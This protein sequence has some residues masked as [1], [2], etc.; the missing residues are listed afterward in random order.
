MSGFQYR[1]AEK[2]KRQREAVFQHWKERNIQLSDVELE[3]TCFR[4]LPFAHALKGE[5]CIS[6]ARM[7]W[8]DLYVEKDGIENYW[9]TTI[10]RTLCTHRRVYLVGSASAG[11][12]YGCSVVGMNFW[13]V[14]PMNSTFLVTSTDKESLDAKAWGTIKDLHTTD[15]LRI[16]TRVEYEDAIVEARNAKQRDI[17]NAIKAIALP[18]GSEGEKAIGKVQGRKNEH[19]A[20]L[21][22][23]FAHMDSF[24]TK[25][26]GNLKS[27]ITFSFWACSN[28][29][30]EGDPMYQEAI[31]D[32]QEYPLGWDTPGLSDLTMWKVK[33]G[34]VCLYFDGEKSPNTLATG[35]KDPFPMLTRR[36]FIQGIRD[37]EGEDGYSW[38]KY[39]KSFPKPGMSHDKVLDQKFLERYGAFGQVTWQGSPTIT[40]AGLDAAWTHGGD[41]CMASFGR[42]GIDT[43]G[44][45]VLAHEANAVKLNS[46]VSGKGTYEE[47]LADAFIEECRKRE[48]HVVS[49]DISGSGG[50]IS[51]AVRDAATKHGWKLEIL[52]VDAA[53]SADESEMYDVGDKRKNGKELFD[54]R[55]SELWIGYRLDVQKGLIR[56]LTAT[57]QA[58][59]ELC[60]RRMST[61]EDKRWELE[62]KKKYKKRNQGKSPD[63]AES[64][65]LCRFSARKHGLGA[66]I[67]RQTV[68]KLESFRKEEKPRTQYAWGAVKRYGW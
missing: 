14:N 2:M 67:A 8:K 57:S 49:V 26:R 10:C 51:N 68:K 20:W 50:R 16:G 29:P 37:E 64:L 15:A 6:L 48:C 35:E 66:S 12:T 19:I 54:R 44:M 1:H 34:G 61:D 39:I 52:A 38:W 5:F 3:M 28:K 21:C 41:A 27:A 46:K 30:E 11:K 53:G 40:V 45:K 22:D 42:L 55:V 62:D 23:E 65:I 24:V 59:K 47:Q 18:K 13:G 56:G 25:A 7:R 31:P 9:F 33:G 43:E 17:R 4:G 58:V 63:S 32:P 36:D 60:E